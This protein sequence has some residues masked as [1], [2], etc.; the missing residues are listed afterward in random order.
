MIA[1]TLLASL[2]LTGCAVAEAD[3]NETIPVQGEGRCDASGAQALIGRGASEA[4]GA[5]A[6]RLSGA[7][8]LRWIQPGDVVTMDYR[9]DR[10][11]IELDASN[12][13]A[14]IRCG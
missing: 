12:R 10:L 8:R 2:A 3:V 1:R 9:T 5:E 6:L 14:A 7:T 13:V 4:L 11:N